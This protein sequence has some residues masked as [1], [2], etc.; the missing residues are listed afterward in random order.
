MAQLRGPRAEP[1]MASL[2]R[3]A[4]A[5]RIIEMSQDPQMDAQRL[6]NDGIARVK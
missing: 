1:A 3:T 4:L 6:T 5:K 2:V